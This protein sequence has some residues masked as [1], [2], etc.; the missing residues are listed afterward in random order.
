MEIQL[1]K[2]EQE[3]AVKKVLKEMNYAEAIFNE[4]GIC[5]LEYL[6][7]IFPIDPNY[8]CL[9][10]YY[11]LIWNCSN[12]DFSGFIKNYAIPLKQIALKSGTKIFNFSFGEVEWNEIKTKNSFRSISFFSDGDILHSKYGKNV[13]YDASYNVLSNDF[14]IDI[15]RKDICTHQKD[16]AS[17]FK[18]ELKDQEI[19]I[20]YCDFEIV[21]NLKNGNTIMNYKTTYSSS[22]ITVKKVISSELTFLLSRLQIETLKSRDKVNG[23]Y[24]FD[25][26]ESNNISATFISRKGKK[27]DIRDLE[28]VDILMKADSLLQKIS[29]A[30]L[31]FI[32]T[33][34]AYSVQKFKKPL[35]CIGCEE[36]TNNNDI[37]VLYNLYEL[38][39]NT[40]KEIKG[41]IPLPGLVERIENFISLLDCH[42]KAEKGISRKIK[43]R[44]KKL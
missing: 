38:I 18:I 3:I 2:E 40:L 12:I 6:K 8:R 1:T 31:P 24:R 10:E 28:N 32:V 33:D 4:W 17:S 13:S 26:D 7:E 35:Y 22:I 5:W 21:C 15:N 20:N 25:K 39:I 27:T 11:D 30:K 23:I 16:K 43:T 37:K 29:Y 9:E 42:R 14:S 44:S 34:F 19:I 36:P 41:E